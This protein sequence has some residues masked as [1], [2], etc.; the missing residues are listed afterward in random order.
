MSF[1]EIPHPA[2]AGFGMTEARFRSAVSAQTGGS[3]YA[4]ASASGLNP[5]FGLSPNGDVIVPCDV[6][7]SPESFRG[8]IL[9][10]RF[11]ECVSPPLSGRTTSRHLLLFSVLPGSS[12]TEISRDVSTWLYMTIGEK[13]RYTSSFSPFAAFCP[14]NFA[15]M[16]LSILPSMTSWTLLV[17]VPVRWSFTIW[18]G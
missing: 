1:W 14:R 5:T 10:T 16:K 8:I 18:Y 2:A 12:T 15:W 11:G 4:P 7:F 3:R 6:N 9:P 13:R 17:S